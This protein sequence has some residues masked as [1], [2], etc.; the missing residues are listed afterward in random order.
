MTSHELNALAAQRCAVMDA[1]VIEHPRLQAAHEAFDFLVEHGRASPDRGKRCVPL[2]AP[3]QAGKSTIIASYAQAKNKPE[4]IKNRIVPV[5]HVT[6]QANSTRRQL[7]QDILGALKFFGHDT[8]P[9][10]GSEA[11]LLR[12]TEHYLKL[13]KVE[14]LVL[15]EIQH[16]VHSDNKK[17]INSVSETV[18]RMLIKGS[19]PIVLSGIEAA[20]KVFE[21]NAQLKHRAEP[22]ID[23]GPLEATNPEHMKLFKEFMAH[24]GARLEKEGVIKR[25]ETLMA[26]G[27]LAAIL[28][29]SGGVLGSAC[30]LLKAAVTVVT[31]DGRDAIT[32]PDLR[33]AAEKAFVEMDLVDGNPFEGE[34]AAL[35]AEA[36]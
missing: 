25:P 28:E 32:T 1:I 20:W 8:L 13:A 3:T 22:K 15:D 21:T 16:L 23:L 18:K 9:E 10:A 29:V 5:L 7:A 31:R 17:V 19:C 4:L 33:Q 35:R 30:N 36:A 6:L 24:Y 26:P 34:F 2:I 11:T 14:L 12:R 27:I